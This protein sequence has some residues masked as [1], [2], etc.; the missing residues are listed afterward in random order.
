MMTAM[1]PKT[2]IVHSSSERARQRMSFSGERQESKTIRFPPLAAEPYSPPSTAP[3]GAAELQF[4]GM[5]EM[6]ALREENDHLK[7]ELLD[8]MRGHNKFISG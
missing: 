8:K 3:A 7:R 6:Q 2:S 4:P 1:R 5:Q